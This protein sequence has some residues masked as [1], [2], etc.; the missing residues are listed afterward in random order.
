MREMFVIKIRQQIEEKAKQ[1]AQEAA[2]EHQIDAS[3]DDNEM[4]RTGDLSKMSEARKD[5][6]DTGK[7][8]EAPPQDSIDAAGK[9]SMTQNLSTASI[10]MLP[11]RDNLDGD[12]KP[13]I[14]EVWRELASNYKRQMRRAFRNIRLQ[15][16][17]ASQRTSELKT[18]FLEF[19]HTSEGK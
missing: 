12:F 3:F 10:Q 4:N 5:P 1:M 7:K 15:R 9:S 11:D 6:V 13:V 2:A 17:Q 19:L 14:V 18:S 8:K 16:E